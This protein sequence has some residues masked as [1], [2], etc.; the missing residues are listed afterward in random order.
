M[1]VLQLM[2][3]CDTLQ[4]PLSPLYNKGARKFYQEYSH[5]PC[6]GKKQNLL[7]SPWK[8]S[9]GGAKRLDKVGITR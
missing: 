7:H 2:E 4:N 1:T 6:K 3:H 5:I 8:Y 9:K